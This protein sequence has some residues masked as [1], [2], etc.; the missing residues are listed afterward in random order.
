[1]INIFNTALRRE[2]RYKIYEN[3]IAGLFCARLGVQ[4]PR[5]KAFLYEFALELGLKKELKKKK[6]AL[7]IGG[8]EICIRICNS[9]SFSFIMLGIRD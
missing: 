2:H 4:S 5:R 1:M 3:K 6:N 9:A 8:C 7:Q